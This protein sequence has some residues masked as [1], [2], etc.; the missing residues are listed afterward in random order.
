MRGISPK[1]F[2]VRRLADIFGVSTGKISMMMRKGA[3]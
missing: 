2:T 1:L 3:A